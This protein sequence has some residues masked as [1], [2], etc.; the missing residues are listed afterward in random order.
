METKTKTSGP[1]MVRTPSEPRQEGIVAAADWEGHALRTVAR[2]TA[3][4]FRGEA[5]EP[6]IGGYLRGSRLG[7]YRF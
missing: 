7:V 6:P 1:L 2:G 4:A 5:V 3:E